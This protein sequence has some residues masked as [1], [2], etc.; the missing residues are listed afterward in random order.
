LL[1]SLVLEWGPPPHDG[2][3]AL[4]SY[5]VEMRCSPNHTPEQMEGLHP[6]Q[7]LALMPHF[8]TIYRWVPWYLMLL[9]HC[10]ATALLIRTML[11][12]YCRSCLLKVVTHCADLCSICAAA[13]FLQRY[14]D[15]CAGDGPVA[16]HHL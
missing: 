15:V 1:Q 5:R 4:T 10:L 9:C 13:V 8:L 11:P 3:S 6:E 2:G 12:C 16:W 14:G 7:T